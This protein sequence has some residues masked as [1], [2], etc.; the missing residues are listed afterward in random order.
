MSPGILVWECLYYTNKL[1]WMNEIY[2]TGDASLQN[3]RKE[4]WRIFR[5]WNGTC[6]PRVVINCLSNSKVL[7]SS[8]SSRFSRKKTV[9]RCACWS[10]QERH[11]PQQNMYCRFT[12]Y[13]AG[14]YA[15]RMWWSKCQDLA[16][17]CFLWK[18]PAIVNF[19]N[20]LNF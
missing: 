5:L 4:H 15:V 13:P 6:S 12:A 10:W 3:S 11:V 2:S 16:M 1:K 20:M 9:R 14:A 19:F 18:S 7:R 17:G 8:R